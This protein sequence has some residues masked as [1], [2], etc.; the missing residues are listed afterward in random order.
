MFCYQ[1][2]CY[3]YLYSRHRRHRLSPLSY[4]FVNVVRACAERVTGIITNDVVVVVDDID[5]NPYH[6]I[7]S[8][9]SR[10]T[11]LLH[12]TF[13]QDPASSCK[14]QLL[15]CR[16]RNRRQ[17]LF[18]VFRTQTKRR[19][20][21]SIVKQIS[22]THERAYSRYRHHCHRYHHHQQSNHVQMHCRER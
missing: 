6:S 4:L 18:T 14:Y 7:C 12:T 9:I 1:F 20:I 15:H 16:R 13:R 10:F 2:Q 22:N 3:H 17:H 11:I 21:F 8:N 5:Q 19:L